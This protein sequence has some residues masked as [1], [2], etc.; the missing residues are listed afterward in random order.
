ME[1]MKKASCADLIKKRRAAV[2]KKYNSLE[3]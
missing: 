3:K 2:C 1:G